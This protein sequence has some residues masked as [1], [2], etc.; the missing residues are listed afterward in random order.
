L[1]ISKILVLELIIPRGKKLSFIP[2]KFSKILS[3]RGHKVKNMTIP[4]SSPKKIQKRN[5]KIF[6]VHEKCQ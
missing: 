6:D 3:I 1:E 4:S 5:S 2:S